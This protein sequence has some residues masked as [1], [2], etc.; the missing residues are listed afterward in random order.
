MDLGQ[1]LVSRGSERLTTVLIIDE[2]HHLSYDL[3][4]EVRLLSNLETTE[5]KLL[6]VALVGQP[7]LD[8]K[9]DSPGLRQLKQRIALRAKLEPLDEDETREYIAQR[10]Q[11]AGADTDREPIF[12]DEAIASVYRYSQGLPRL[13]NTICN[14][15]L[16]SGYASQAQTIAP[17]II[18]EV[19]ADLRLNQQD[20]KDLNLPKASESTRRAETEM[21]EGATV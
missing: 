2:A 10:L 5:D 1:F 9:L 11:I 8:E 21:E 19:A 13:I 18:S 7:E 16:I 15:A 6:Q 12:S 3:L 4:E 14:N 20:S 17:M